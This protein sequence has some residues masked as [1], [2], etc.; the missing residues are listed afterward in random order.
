MLCSELPSHAHQFASEIVTDKLYAVIFSKRS[1]DLHS[2]LTQNPNSVF[3][4]PDD[5]KSSK[6]AHGIMMSKRNIIAYAGCNNR[7]MS[8]YSQ[9]AQVQIKKVQRDEIHGQR[10]TLFSSEVCHH[11]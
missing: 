9:E 4:V 6:K 3:K 5:Q 7:N 1:C 2:L 10:F 11:S 8:S